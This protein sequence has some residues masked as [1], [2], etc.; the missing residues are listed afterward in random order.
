MSAL[1]FLCI[2]TY[3]LNFP[4]IYDVQP[5]NVEA[6]MCCCAVNL[7]NYTI[8]VSADI[9]SDGIVRRTGMTHAFGII[10]FATGELD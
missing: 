10:F 4:G 7:S 3:K 9:V 2:P 5:F 8:I 6:G 1:K